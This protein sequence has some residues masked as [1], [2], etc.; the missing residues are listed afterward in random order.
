M[1]VATQPIPVDAMAGRER[2]ELIL[3]HLDQLPTLPVFVAR[4]LAVT[5]S[6][7]SSARDVIEIIETDAALTA[8]ILR[9]VRRA[10]LGARS[11]EMT[12]ARAVSLL[13]FRAVRNAVLST[14][15]FGVFSSG[16]GDEKALADRGELWRH[17]LGVACLAEA[18]AQR[19]QVGCATADAFVCGLL[20]D[21][22]KIA[23]DACLPKSYSR[24]IETARAKRRCICE[25]EKDLFG[26]DHTI[27]GK[28]LTSRWGLPRAIV[29][30]AWLHHQG[31]GMLPSTIAAPDL[32]KI[33]HLA[34]GLVRANGVGY[35]GYAGEADIDGVAS[36]LGLSSDDLVAL[37][38][39][40]PK[41]MLPLLEL[42]GLDSSDHVAQGAH[43][44]EVVERQLR[45]INAELCVKNEEFNARSLFFDALDHF[46]G[47][48][49]DGARPAQVCE[50]AAEA[51][52]GT[53]A[54][55][56]ALCW[57]MSAHSTNF[58]VAVSR[59]GSPRATATALD[60]RDVAVFGKTARTERTRSGQFGVASQRENE[61][62]QRIVGSPPHKPLRW[63]A[64]AGETMTGGLLFCASADRIASHR[65]GDN[66]CRALASAIA[67]ASGAAWGRMSAEGM[68]EELVELNRKLHAAQSD[69]LRMRSMSMISEMAAG[70]AHELNNPLAVISGRAQMEHARASDPEQ[71][72]A[73]QTII[74]QT[75]RA[76]EI[77]MDLMRF[78]KPEKPTPIV[79]PVS[80]VLEAVYEHWAGDA[81]II[82]DRLSLDLGD[83]DATVFA[84]AGQLI[85]MLNH[86]V[87]NA[88]MAVA[89]N[90]G[91]VTLRSLP[92]TTSEMVRIMVCDDGCGMTREVL[93]H[94]IDPFFSH[95]KAGRGRGLGLSRAYRLAEVNAGNWRIDS[96]P[97]TGTSVVVELPRRKTHDTPN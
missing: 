80:A 53:F 40:L 5:L 71:K 79:Q 46:A 6:E 33:V 85:E 2:A 45:R 65:L 21:I 72:Q 86:L 3:S 95:R 82:G 76:S 28:R 77:V 66:D 47:N 84:D 42:V 89:E 11:D 19:A 60:R 51:V 61:L 52:A 7:E 16:G 96:T 32:V 91:S 48:V 87:A 93:E 10:D 69:L 68:A 38:G 63:I 62:W 29:E 56:G 36:E 83:Q 14:Q 88:V 73:F 90:S 67:M 41:R 24:V 81:S 25:A 22:G 12:V 35:S 18:I 55:Q 15:F 54:P 31:S 44:R 74:E 27:A 8:G 43:A 39:S 26:M 30:C 64:I 50:A 57:L 17:S 20:H 92:G 70:A 78:A 23:L 4:L 94:A 9:L 34:D 37:A 58:Y 97:S 59:R 13:G 1:T 49:G 75:Q